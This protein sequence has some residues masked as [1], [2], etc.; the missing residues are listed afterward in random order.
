MMREWNAEGD[1]HS[2]SPNTNNSENTGAGVI[3][4][5]PTG[6]V[7][8]S[9]DDTQG[10]DG[11]NYVYVAIRRP[12]KP[13][14]AGTDVLDIVSRA[15]TGSTAVVNTNIEPVDFVITKSTNQSNAPVAL[16]RLL[17]NHTNALNSNSDSNTNIFGSSASFNPWDVQDG[18]RFSSDGDTNGGSA[19]TYI[20]YFFR[21]AP[22]FFDVVTYGGTTPAQNVNHNLGVAPELMIVK[23]RST[24]QHWA[25]YNGDLPG[26]GKFISLNNNWDGNNTNSSFWDSTAP[27]ASVFRVGASN[28][29]VNTVNEE[30]IAYLFASLDGISKVGTY[31]GTGNDVNVDCDFAA[32]ARFVMIK[33]TDS[34]GDWYV[35]DSTRGIVA[36]DDPWIALNTNPAQ[37]Q[38]TYNDFIDPYTSGFTV[39]SSA[40]DAL[41]ASEGTYLFLAIA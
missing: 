1:S 32:G 24:S 37:A 39:T 4:P 35:F 15:G 20:N 6:F 25:V 29:Y 22:G 38:V 3:H 27:T 14:T 10:G 36:G 21:R 28:S 19:W 17:G 34:T 5:T 12:H 18:I 7:A 41:N 30:Y 9:N 26:S 11:T 16:T 2:L 23:V 40:P 31:N 13:P 33:R 8:I